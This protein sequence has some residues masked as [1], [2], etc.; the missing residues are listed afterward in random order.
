MILYWRVRGDRNRS[1]RLLQCCCCCC[2]CTRSRRCGRRGRI[3]LPRSAHV[4]NGKTVAV[5][6]VAAAVAAIAAAA[7]AATAKRLAVSKPPPPVSR[8]RGGVRALPFGR[9]DDNHNNNNIIV[10]TVLLIA[11]IR[12]Y[13]PLLFLYHFFRVRCH[14]R[15]PALALLL[16]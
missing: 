16:S 9:D 11:K 2:A 1:Q 6:Q 13:I 5:G 15:P 3:R 10:V 8:P 14:R 4:R 12:R 7:A